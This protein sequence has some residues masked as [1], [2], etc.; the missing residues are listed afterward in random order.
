MRY[1]HSLQPTTMLCNNY[2]YYFSFF[3]VFCRVLPVVVCIVMHRTVAYYVVP[4]IPILRFC[5]PGPCTLLQSADIGTDNNAADNG[6]HH[7]TDP[8]QMEHI[9]Q[10]M[11]TVKKN[12]T[13][14]EWEK[15]NWKMNKKIK[16]KQ[17]MNWNEWAWMTI[18]NI[19]GSV[20][21]LHRRSLHIKR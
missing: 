1:A 4:P 2:Y 13:Y 21:Q 20:Q 8:S 6:T 9:T 3:F 10:R 18:Y 16:Q 19:P 11:R 15:R 14:T 7:S 17:K 5:R 12:D